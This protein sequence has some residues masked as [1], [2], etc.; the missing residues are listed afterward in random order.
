MLTAWKRLL[1]TDCWSGLCLA[2]SPTKAAFEGEKGRTKLTCGCFSTG[3]EADEMEETP[4]SMAGF[5]FDEH[6]GMYYNTQLGCYFD[7]KQQLYGDASSGQWYSFENGK[8]KLI[9]SA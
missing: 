6:S 7:A 4:S 1:H 8:Y 5:Q 2:F 3:V 9:Q